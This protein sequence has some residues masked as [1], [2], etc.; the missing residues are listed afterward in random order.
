ME[1]SEFYSRLDTA[2]AAFGFSPKVTALNMINSATWFPIWA[3]SNVQGAKQYAK[4][5]PMFEPM[6]DL[7]TGV[8]FKFFIGQPIVT[9]SVDADVRSPS[10]MHQIA[11]TFQSCLISATSHTLRGNLFNTQTG[12]VYGILLCVFF[13]AQKAAQFVYSTQS[14]CRIKLL[15]KKVFVRPWAIDVATRKVVSDNRGWFKNF[16]PL[17]P[18]KLSDSL[19]THSP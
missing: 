8:S 18:D 17:K 2:L 4:L 12:G 19:F 5:V 13:D 7:S 6:R 16:G 1:R 10:E 14:E 11:T 3:G 9:C 15:S